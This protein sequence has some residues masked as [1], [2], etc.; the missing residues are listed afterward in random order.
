MKRGLSALTSCG[1]IVG[2]LAATANAQFT[3]NFDYANNAALQA[4]WGAPAV[5][6]A[7]ATSFTY[8]AGGGKLNATGMTDSNVGGFGTAIFNRTTN[9]AGNFVARMEFDW[10]QSATL[11]AMFMEVRGASG[12]IASGG[13]GDDT[14]GPGHAYLQVG[15]ATTYLGPNGAY[16]APAQTFEAVTGAIATSF[17]N[18]PIV[19]AAAD[20]VR[21]GNSL[22]NVGTARLDIV[23]VG[24]QI[25]AYIDNGVNQYSLGPVAGSTE[26][27]TSISLVFA[28]FAYGGPTNV[29]VGDTGTHIG[30]DKIV[31]EPRRNPGDANGDGT[32][33][34]ADYQIIQANS[35]TKQILGTNGDVNYDGTVNFDDFH[36]WKTSFPGGVAAAEA[37]IAAI[38][39]PASLAI[40]VVGAAMTATVR[41]GRRRPSNAC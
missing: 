25:S 11:G 29:L 26:N 35:F 39:E 15:G 24:N 34:I 4:V 30:I 6:G 31:L 21:N 2:L 8:N 17:N 13:L 19:S 7:T 20:A 27:V 28:G 5:G 1:L 32:I 16:G 22:G 12:V 18:A 37:A 33:S 14:G 10:N 3:D 38:P 9:F 40:M 23:R 36:Q 41:R